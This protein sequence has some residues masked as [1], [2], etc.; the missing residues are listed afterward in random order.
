MRAFFHPDQRLHTPRFFLM[1]GQIR[2][3]FEV[4][5]RTEALLEGLAALRL[6]PETPALPSRT[7]LETVH[8]PDYLDYLAGAAAAWAALPDAGPEVVPNM[9]AT[10]DALANGAR[11]PESIVG[12]AAWYSADN[13]CPIGPGTWEASLAAAGTALAAAAEAA[14]GRT[15]YALCRPPGHHAY[16]AR[17]GGHC[18]LNNTALAVE[19]LRRAGA[20]RIATIDIDSHHGNGTQGLF[21][22]DGGVFTFSVHGDPHRYYPFFT[23]HAEERGAG[24]GEG[25]NL[26]APLPFGTGDEAW[27]EAIRSGIAAAQRFGAEALVVSLGFDASEHEPLNALSVTADGFARAGALLGSMKRP[28][29]IIQEG[30]YCVDW[31]GRLLERFLAGWGEAA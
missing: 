4:P 30:G 21:W 24:A 20:K 5:P 15:A 1:R 31:L 11:R 10:A 6:V 22:E 28:T 12:Q 2:P 23:G 26:N 25:L 19:A 29:A 9:H 14:A 16:R 18:Y 13:A 17:A 8:A 7:L 27:L 3:N